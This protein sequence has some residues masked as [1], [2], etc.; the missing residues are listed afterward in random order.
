MIKW[1]I[2]Y[3][4]SESFPRS[5]Y[6]FWINNLKKNSYQSVLIFPIMCFFIVILPFRKRDRH[7]LHAVFVFV[8]NKSLICSSGTELINYNKHDRGVVSDSNC[9][10]R[11]HN[12]KQNEINK[13]K[14]YKAVSW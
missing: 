1:I 14:I 3:E 9:S 2:K 12:R 10:F 7:F 5:I 11:K 6:K 4:I 13:Q 8:N